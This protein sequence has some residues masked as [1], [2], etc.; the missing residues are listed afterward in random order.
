MLPTVTAPPP[1]DVDIEIVWGK[2]LDTVRAN[3]SSNNV[4]RYYENIIEDEYTQ[5]CKKSNA[6]ESD[7]C[8]CY[9]NFINLYELK[10][11]TNQYLKAHMEM[12]LLVVFNIG[13][14][15]GVLFGCTVLYCVHDIYKKCKKV[16]KKTVELQRRRDEVTRAHQVQEIRLAAHS[17]PHNSPISVLRNNRNI[18]HNENVEIR[19]VQRPQPAPRH[20]I[21]E[22]EPSYRPSSTA[23][24]INKLFG[25]REPRIIN[26]N[27]ERPLSVR[28]TPRETPQ[29]STS[30][31]IVPDTQENITPFIHLI[32]ENNN[33]ENENEIREDPI[34]IEIESIR[35]STPPPPYRSI[36]EL[37]V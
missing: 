14:F 18:N 30:S 35:S 28:P 23:Q 36:F 13:V 8:E 4:T 6:E 19:N 11:Q 7:L 2:K 24:L 16:K 1:E 25:N 21:A 27:E 5:E 34:D 22:V 3:R 12:R 17:S 15:L 10:N 37:N 20:Y 31:H 32:P 26:R 33:E 29:P 9:E